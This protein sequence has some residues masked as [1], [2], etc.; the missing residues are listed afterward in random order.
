MFLHVCSFTYYIPCP[1]VRLNSGTPKQMAHLPVA[2]SSFSQSI[3]HQ[4]PTKCNST[5]L[6][7]FIV[8]NF[9]KII[10]CKSPYKDVQKNHF[11]VQPHLL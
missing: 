5:Q 11:V 7:I 2:L 10:F 1:F 3:D 6:K 8:M 4:P 9:Y